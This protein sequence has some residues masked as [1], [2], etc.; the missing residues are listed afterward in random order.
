MT[1]LSAGAPRIF[2]IPDTYRRTVDVGRLP[3]PDVDMTAAFTMHVHTVM[4]HWF[5]LY[6]CHYRVGYEGLQPAEIK[7][8]IK[9]LYDDNYCRTTEES[10]EPQGIVN[11]Q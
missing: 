7:I 3:T 9:G 2:F 4:I 11:G 1:R 6:Q 8:N 10:R 5:H